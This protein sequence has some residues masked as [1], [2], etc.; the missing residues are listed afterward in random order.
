VD[1]QALATAMSHDKKGQ[2]GHMRLVLLRGPGRPGVF[3]A[4]PEVVEAGWSAVWT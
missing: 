4:T 2:S 1:R 3:E